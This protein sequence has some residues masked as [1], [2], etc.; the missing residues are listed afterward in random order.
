MK[1]ITKAKKFYREIPYY[2]ELDGIST[3]G[4]MD[5]ILEED[6]GLALFDY[7]FVNE[8]EELIEL[9]H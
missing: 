4:C 7:K 2:I 1:R 6:D 9:K 3:R 8:E 5:L